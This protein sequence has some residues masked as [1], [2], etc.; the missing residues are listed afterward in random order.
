ME[1]NSTISCSAFY[2]RRLVAICKSSSEGLPLQCQTPWTAASLRRI[3]RRGGVR[4]Q[5]GDTINIHHPLSRPADASRSGQTASSQ[6][7]P[8]RP[9]HYH[10]V[11]PTQYYGPSQ[12]L[13]HCGTGVEMGYG[14]MTTKLLNC[15]YIENSIYIYISF[16]L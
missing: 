3:R 9:P 11:A 13:I 16:I 5:L 2:K 12:T 15:I 10:Q 6:P 14:W 4:G 7:L 1:F 8:T